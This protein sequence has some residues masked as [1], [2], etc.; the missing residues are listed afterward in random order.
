MWQ[1]Q[2]QMIIAILACASATYNTWKATRYMSRLVSTSQTLHCA[3]RSNTNFRLVWERG[4]IRHLNGLGLLR[5]HMVNWAKD[6]SQMFILTSRDQ[7][8]IPELIHHQMAV[9]YRRRKGGSRREWKQSFRPKICQGICW[10]IY[11]ST[12]KSTYVL[13][14]K[15]LTGGQ[16]RIPTKKDR[17]H[18]VLGPKIDRGWMLEGYISHSA[19]KPQPFGL[20]EVIYSYRSSIITTHHTFPS[21]IDPAGMK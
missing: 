13:R 16:I 11:R 7:P 18:F 3:A 6:Q 15:W 17:L 21:T 10:L 2:S 5:Y 12:W 14:K 4:W 1:L 9:K 19:R 20:I 8:Q